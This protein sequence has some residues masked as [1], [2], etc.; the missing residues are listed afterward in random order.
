MDIS[1][2][3]VMVL[4][5]ND[6]SKAYAKYRKFYVMYDRTNDY[7]AWIGY[8]KRGGIILYKPDSCSWDEIRTMRRSQI[9]ILSAILYDYDGCVESKDLRELIIE[10]FNTVK[11]CFI[12]Y[13][14]ILYGGGGTFEDETSEY[15]REFGTMGYDL[16]SFKYHSCVMYR[17]PNDGYSDKT[18]SDTYG[19]LGKIELLEQCSR[20]YYK[21]VVEYKNKCSNIKDDISLMP[22]FCEQEKAIGGEDVYRIV[23]KE[24]RFGNVDDAYSEQDQYMH[25]VLN[26]IVTVCFEALQYEEYQQN[27]QY[28]QQKIDEISDVIHTYFETSKNI[29]ENN[30]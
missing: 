13:P 22:T 21:M 14:S 18:V 24:Y 12:G 16:P 20:D 5:G 6:K 23:P 17:I 8:F 9:G 30:K 28:W 4:S 26:Q 3:D 7:Q 2:K 29:G 10:A 27:E 15:E 1:E 19:L 25:E 11:D